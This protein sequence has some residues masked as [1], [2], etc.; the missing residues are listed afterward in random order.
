[1]CQSVIFCSHTFKNSIWFSVDTAI[2]L[3]GIGVFLSPLAPE[4]IANI[5]ITNCALLEKSYNL[6]NT[7]PDSNLVTVPVNVSPNN[8]Y[9]IS[10]DIKGKGFS[11]AGRAQSDEVIVDGLNTKGQFVKKVEF[12]FSG[13]SQNELG[14]IPELYFEVI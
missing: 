14:Q 2:V 4:I 6:K 3:T 7:Q 9:N 5:G 10:V 1:M 8:F 11:A 13:R 12:T